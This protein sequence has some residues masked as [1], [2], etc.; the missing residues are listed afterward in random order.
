M[1]ECTFVCYH[2]LADASNSVQG[3]AE[4]LSVGLGLPA[5]TIYDA[6]RYG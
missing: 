4:M 3:V 2:A 5:S 1:S 6:S